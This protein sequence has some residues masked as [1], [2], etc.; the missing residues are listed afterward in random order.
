MTEELKKE[1][2]GETKVEDTKKSEPTI[3]EDELVKTLQE[4]NDIVK[5]RKKPEEEE[6]EEEDEEEDEE[7]SVTGN[8]EEDETIAK[9]IE[10]S[11]FLA[12]LVDQTEASAELVADKV[13]S[14]EKSVSK[15]DEKLIV[16]LGDI[17]KLIKGVTDTITEKF[18]KVDDRLSKIEQTPVSLPK[19]V[20]KKGAVLE[21]SF[22][23]SDAATPEGVDALP[24]RAVVELLEKAVGD[25]KIKDSFLFSY[26]GDPLFR[27]PDGV[28]EV[29]KSYLPK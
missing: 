10:V 3:T 8:F 4:L 11:D 26:E 6:E 27:L 21:K 17:G 20:M 16:S 13:H 1:K 23:A 9:A 29:L 24:K 14:L 19:S 15:F 25:G 28:K 7:K 5:A 12:A 22:S 2:E 18:T